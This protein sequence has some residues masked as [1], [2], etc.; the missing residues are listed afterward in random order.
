MGLIQAGPGLEPVGRR[1][2][3]RGG[4]ARQRARTALRGCALRS[5]NGTQCDQ[6]SHERAG[7]AS[8]DAFPARARRRRDDGKTTQREAGGNRIKAHRDCKQE[9]ADPGFASTQLAK[10]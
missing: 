5:A 3:G 6:Q 4:L 9:L 8:T 1:G 2:D 10:R 7:R